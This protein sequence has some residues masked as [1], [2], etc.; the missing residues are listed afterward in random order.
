MHVM[1]TEEIDAFLAKP[2][3]AIIATQRR[4]GGSQLT[5]M[6]FYWD[7]AAF[8]MSTTRDRN[9]Y[10]NIKRN[11]EISLIVNDQQAH[12]YVSTYGR[13]ELIEGDKERIMEL[14]LPIIRCY[15]PEGRAEQMAASLLE[16]DR[17]VIVLRPDKVV[18]S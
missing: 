8:Y 5:P 2:L 1:T 14:T 9:K 10:A 17:V 15:A 12:T 6:W 4:A 16:Q 13:A 7:G 3:D 18:T 11:A